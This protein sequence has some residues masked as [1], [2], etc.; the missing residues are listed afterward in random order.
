MILAGFAWLATGL[1]SANVPIVFIAGALV[2]VVSYGFLVHMLIAFPS[3]LVR[4][5]LERVVVIAGYLS[6]TV[7]QLLP[8][9]FL[10][11]EV[12]A[13]CINC[14]ANPLLLHADNDLANGLF[15]LQAALGSLVLIVFVVALVKR[16]R[17]TPDRGSERVW[18]RSS[19][20]GREPSACRPSF[21]P[22][23]SPA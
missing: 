20:R 5:G 11:T 1:F 3:G 4:S 15:G 16:W 14:P 18:P 23:A 10:D 6:V 22:P 19:G 12:D 8:M 21:S 17:S 9:L 7:G 13:D 2:G